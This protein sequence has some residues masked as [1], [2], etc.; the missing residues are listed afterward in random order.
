MRC[1][2]RHEDQIRAAHDF[3]D[4][5]DLDASL[6]Q[7]RLGTCF[8]ICQP[9][10]AQRLARTVRG[11]VADDRVALRFDRERDRQTELPQAGEANVHGVPRTS[12]VTPRRQS[13]PQRW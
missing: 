9:A 13:R 4:R 6:L 3:V 8:A 2:D 1:L 11:I 12:S 7:E 5:N 10:R